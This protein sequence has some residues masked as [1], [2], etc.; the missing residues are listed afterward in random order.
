MLAKVQKDFDFG[1]KESTDQLYHALFCVYNYNHENLMADLAVLTLEEA[2]VE[3][4]GE[5]HLISYCGFVD[6]LQDHYTTYMTWKPLNGKLGHSLEC[7]SFFLQSLDGKRI[8][9]P[10]GDLASSFTRL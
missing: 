5:Q 8:E 4:S 2:Q 7:V 6:F 3:F 1:K 10:E 9:I